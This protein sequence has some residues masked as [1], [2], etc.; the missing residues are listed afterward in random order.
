[1]MIKNMKWVLLILLLCYSFFALA[2]NIV[3]IN[4]ADLKTLISLE[5]IGK[6]KA[7][8][9]IKYRE[10]NGSFE[11]L[12]DLLKVKG[13]GKKALAANRERIT[14]KDEVDSKSD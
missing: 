9:I 11:S 2:A 6:V 8:A 5:L 7:T 1:M 4:T 12:K 10:K 3:N 13:I 14:L